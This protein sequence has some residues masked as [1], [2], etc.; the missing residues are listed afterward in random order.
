MPRNITI[1]LCLTVVLSTPASSTEHE[2]GEQGIWTNWDTVLTAGVDTGWAGVWTLRAAVLEAGGNSIQFPLAGH[3]LT[4]DNHGNYMMNYNTAHMLSASEV[5]TP[6]FTGT[7][8]WVPPAGVMPA[9]V[10]QSC[11]L[12]G[13]ISG[14]AGGRLFAPF[15]VDLDRLG[16]E[17]EALFGL[18]WM[19]AAFNPAMAI[20]PTIVCPGAEVDV[21]IKGGAAVMPIGAG[22]GSVTDN[23]PVVIYDYEIDQNLTTLIMI[24]RGSPR[25]TYVWV[26]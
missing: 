3:T 24:S 4:I 14:M 17:G 8:E 22:R 7:F 6:A 16:D 23:G 2:I 1:A 13:Q 19:E 9:G 26:K 18:P 5:Q 20:K 12:T 10:P 11:A 21:T 25:L 15:D